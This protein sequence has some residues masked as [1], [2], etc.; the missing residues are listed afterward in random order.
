MKTP[1]VFSNS[2]VTLTES[3]SI[4]GDFYV[5][6]NIVI[7]DLYGNVTLEV[8]GDLV[9]N[10]RIENGSLIVHGNLEC[11]YLDNIKNEVDGNIYVSET[12]DA[13]ELISNFGHII[14]AGYTQAYF[15]TA[16]NGS[17]CSKS[18]MDANCIAAFDDIIVAETLYA[19]SITSGNGLFVN[20]NIVIPSISDIDVFSRDIHCETFMCGN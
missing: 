3:R 9:V 11:K 18:S 13:T 14:T 17:I 16:F 12:V 2:D 19:N 4:H 7:D 20:Q 5:D 15:I 8:F 1:I 10:G 6:G